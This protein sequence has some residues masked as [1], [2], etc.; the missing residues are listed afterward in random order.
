[1][2]RCLSVSLSMRVSRSFCLSRSLHVCLSV[3]LFIC[4]SSAASLCVNVGSSVC[5]SVSR[6]SV[7]RSSRLPLDFK[8]TAHTNHTSYI[9]LPP[10]FV[11]VLYRPVCLSIALSR[12][13]FLFVLLFWLIPPYR[14]VHLFA[15]LCICFFAFL[16]A[17][18]TACRSAAQF[19]C[20]FVCLCALAPVAARR[21]SPALQCKDSPTGQ[22]HEGAAASSSPNCSSCCS[23]GRLCVGLL[24]NSSSGHSGRVTSLPAFAP[25]LPLPRRPSAATPAAPA[26]SPAAAGE[27]HVARGRS[28]PP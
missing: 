19:V 3:C 25:R 5:V 7:C 17:G 9:C 24:S 4:R 27:G 6:V 15:C 28:L 12:R 20:L 26:A 13:L 2:N 11:F 14:S 1:M 16:S 21:V 10:P 22:D 8:N 18:Q 23:S